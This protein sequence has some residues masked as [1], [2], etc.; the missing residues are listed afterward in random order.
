MQFQVPQFVEV[1]D[2]IFG[3][4]TA[5]QFVYLVGGGGFLLALWLTVPHWVA[6][7][8]GGPVALLGAALA[9][10]KINDRP[11][12]N[13][14]ESGFQYLFR[15]KLYIW[16]KKQPKTVL[17]EEIVLP[18]QASE[19][20]AKYVPSATANKIKDLAWSLDIKESVYG[21]KNQR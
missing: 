11:L 20:P 15:T 9:F 5:V 16:E 7:L 12:V 17:P 13:A 10:Y 18:G 4:L 1:E 3:P 2:K 14:L 8:L 6:I 19:D 21:N